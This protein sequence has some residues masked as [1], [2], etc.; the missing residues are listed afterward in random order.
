MEQTFIRSRKIVE[1]LDGDLAALR[2]RPFARPEDNKAAIAAAQEKARANLEPLANIRDALRR[3]AAAT[4][5][6]PASASK[7]VDPDDVKV[8]RARLN[9]LDPVQILGEYAAAAATGDMA[10][11]VAVNGAHPS[12]YPVIHK[13]LS[14]N[15]AIR[16]EVT[17]QVRQR[18]NP[19]A[20]RWAENKRTLADGIGA[21]VGDVE[22]LVGA[23]DSIARQAAG[24]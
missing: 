6:L 16:H 11:L 17:T 19:D 21:V 24:E 1:E 22:R 3:D 20:E 9:A 10:T 4:A 18:A 7:G 2:Q 13:A 12:A 5:D 23:P 8:I 14:A 15:P